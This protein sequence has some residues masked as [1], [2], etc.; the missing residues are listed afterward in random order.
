MDFLL[1]INWIAL[2]ALSIV[3]L[4]FVLIHALSKKMNRTLLTLLALLFGA[5]VGI[6]FA[7]EGNTYL[8]WVELIGNIYVNVI[9]ALAAPIILVSIISSFVSLKSKDAVK[10][11]GV[12]SVFW[13]L[14]SAAGAIVLSLFAGS[15]FGLWERSAIF[16]NITTVSDST[17]QAY[18]DLKRSFDEVLLGLFPSNVVGDVANN[19]IVAII[20]IAATVALAYIGVASSE[21]EDKVVSFKNFVEATKKILF[22]ILRL[23]VDITPYAVLCLIASSAAAIFSDID[24]ILQLLLLVGI[25]YAV[26]FFHAYVFNGLLIKFAAKLNPLKFFKKIF[27]AQATAFT[28]QSS[29]GTLPV[30]IDCLENRVGVTERIANFTAPLGTT[31][32]MPGCTCVWPVLLVMFFV[33]AAGLD[34][35]VGNYIL[36]AIVTLVLSLGSAGVPGIAIVSSVAVFGAL[37]LPI[38]AVVLLIPINTISDMART[39]NNATTAAVAAAIVARKEGQI[40]DAVFNKEEVGSWVTVQ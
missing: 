29:I 30:T 13:L 3:G 36:L 38:A 39:L 23:V 18:G 15:V 21:G 8:V 22:K 11:I 17:V 20:I 4:L 34:W 6:V 33:N 37:N 1:S 14:T 32:G 35:S 28:T 5:V 40:D 27:Q 9:T 10:S 16:D 19:N 26:S 7:S 25:I 24:T 12:R 2:F 31:I